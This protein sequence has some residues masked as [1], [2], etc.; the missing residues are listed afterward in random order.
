METK[1]NKNEVEAVVQERYHEWILRQM[2]RYR[3]IKCPDCGVVMY[4]PNSLI[5]PGGEDR[6]HPSQWRKDYDSNV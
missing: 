4:E 3:M 2:R 1:T 5:I 6:T